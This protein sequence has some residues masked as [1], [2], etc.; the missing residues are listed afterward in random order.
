[1]AD[2]TKV[3][4]VLGKVVITLIIILIGINVLYLMTLCSTRQCSIVNISTLVLL[5]WVAAF[6]FV[7]VRHSKEEKK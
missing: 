7:V 2:S 5:V 4:K 6:W 3:F 1:M